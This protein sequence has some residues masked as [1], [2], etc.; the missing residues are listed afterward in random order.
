MKPKTL[1]A[2][3][4]ITA[5]LGAFV[6][7]VER[8]LPSTDERHALGKKV[9]TLDAEE[10]TGVVLRFGEE[11]IRLEK[12]LRDAGGEGDLGAAA[13]RL[14]EP[15]EARADSAQVVGLL[16]RL[17]GLEKARTLEAIDA[18]ALGLAEPRA[19]VVFETAKGTHSLK[20]GADL[21]LGGGVVVQ[22]DAPETAY[23]VDGASDLWT[24][25]TRPPGDWR[26][27]SLFDGRRSEIERIRLVRGDETLEL[28]RRGDAEV[29]WLESPI[30]DRADAEAISGLLTTLSGLQAQRFADRAWSASD[31]EGASR[32]EVDLEGRTEPWVLELARSADQSPVDGELV[33]AQRLA[34]ADGQVAWIDAAAGL[35]R[36]L[37]S[38]AEQWRSRSLSALQVFAVDRAR[39]ELA[40]SAGAGGG[41]SA[42]A[43]IFD[44][45]RSSGDWQRDG[46]TVPYDA[47]SDALYALAESR[48]EELISRPEAAA[49]GFDLETPRLRV[50]LTSSSGVE[51]SIALYGTGGGA[52]AG[53]STAQARAA[54]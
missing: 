51:E 21:P 52:A 39:F 40:E 12:D 46:V 47:A 18:E 25:L 2:L 42:A 45:A 13:W 17:T 54:A 23:R 24:E 36:P 10:V 28:A 32:I 6:L 38:S 48:A 30:E 34:R 4:L 31:G 14:T 35:E 53:P 37:S 19:S 11:T 9:L 5:A 7:L 8:D 20:L 3:V 27:R 41:E 50:I 16:D 49:R 44:I 22:G 1:L 43:A 33:S 26:D 15:L 29:F